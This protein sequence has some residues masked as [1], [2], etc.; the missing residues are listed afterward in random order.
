MGTVNRRTDYRINL[1]MSV[2]EHL[3]DATRQSMSLNLGTSGIFLNRLI[4]PICREGSVVGLEFELPD[5]SE[6]IWAR[7]K[8]R[9]DTMDKYFHGTG[10]EFS[11]MARA[12]ERLVHD[13]I[14]EQREKQLQQL[15]TLIHRNRKIHHYH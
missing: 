14:L 6:V 8:I 7:G 9:Y 12:H 4:Q 13:Y 5:T 15:L 3:R 11:G 1:Q 2:N 10:V